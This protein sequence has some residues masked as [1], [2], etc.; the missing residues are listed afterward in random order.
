MQT[1]TLT[2]TTSEGSAPPLPSFLKAARPSRE[3][4]RELLWR[5]AELRVAG[6]IED[7][8]L[9][10]DMTLALRHAGRST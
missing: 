8:V 3:L 2:F 10:L 4:I 7:A 6:R 1:E 9:L 5:Q